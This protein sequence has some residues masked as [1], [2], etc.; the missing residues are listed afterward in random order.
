MIEIVAAFGI[1][2]GG[3][4]AAS[5]GLGT[6]RPPAP[7]APVESDPRDPIVLDVDLPC[8]WCLAPTTEAD[9]RC[10]SCGQRFG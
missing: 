9:R 5:S 2:V 6:R 7:P 3:M 1:V 8:P 4:V 10:P